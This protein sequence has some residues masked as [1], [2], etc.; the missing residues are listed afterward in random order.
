MDGATREA[1]LITTVA[2]PSD[3]PMNAMCRYDETM[4]ISSNETMRVSS[5]ETM[6]IK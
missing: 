6:S 1:C 3:R 5:D 2:L 4:R